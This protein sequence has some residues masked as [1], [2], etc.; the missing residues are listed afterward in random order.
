MWFS[1]VTSFICFFVELIITNCL[2]PINLF[3][4]FGRS[5]HR[6][7]IM[8][9]VHYANVFTIC[10]H[11]DNMNWYCYVSILYSMSKCGGTMSTDVSVLDQLEV[12]QPLIQ[13]LWEIFIHLNQHKCLGA[14][15]KPNH[16]WRT[17]QGRLLK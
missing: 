3:W 12:R 16:R 13:K 1:F 15:R 17:S 14:K 4:F 11:I 9:S 7:S 10:L 6:W 2:G 5:H 8:V